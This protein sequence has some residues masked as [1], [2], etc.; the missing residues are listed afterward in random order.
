MCLIS[1]SYSVVTK[2][3]PRREHLHTVKEW[4]QDFGGQCCRQRAE[5][6]PVMLPGCPAPPGQSAYWVPGIAW[7]P[8]RARRLGALGRT[9]ILEANRSGLGS[10]FCQAIPLSSFTFNFL[11]FENGN[12]IIFL[13]DLFQ[14]SSEKI[15]VKLRCSIVG[16]FSYCLLHLIWMKDSR[17]SARQWIMA[18]WNYFLLLWANYFLDVNDAVRI[19]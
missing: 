19:G 14:G 7:A 1:L 5:Q 15:Q 3:L 6:V 4:T 8:W 16:S 18:A 9:Q 17:R 2:V 10:R 12:D 13:A 11:I